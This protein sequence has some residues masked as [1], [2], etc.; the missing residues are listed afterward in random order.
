MSLPILFFSDLNIGF[1]REIQ[2]ENIC[3]IYV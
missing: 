3:I 2:D 1:L